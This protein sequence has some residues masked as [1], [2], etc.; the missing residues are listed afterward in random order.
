VAKIIISTNYSFLSSFCVC[1]QMVE[2][3]FG[4]GL[5]KVSINYAEVVYYLS[6]SQPV[7]VKAVVVVPVKQNSTATV[8]GS[9]LAGRKPCSFIFL[10][11]V[12]QFLSSIERE[13]FLVCWVAQPFRPATN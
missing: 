7:W 1:L 5:V 11:F 4:R 6:L 9:F 12:P 8:S 10:E 13:P 3:L 2:M